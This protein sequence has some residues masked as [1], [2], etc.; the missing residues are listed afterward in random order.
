MAPHKPLP[1]G[2]T[3]CV[4]TIGAASKLVVEYARD[5][6]KFARVGDLAGVPKQS[7]PE[8][9]PVPAPLKKNWFP[10]WMKRSR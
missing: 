8:P 7:P 4:F 5:F 6:K 1:N 2:C 10:K 3:C 9:T